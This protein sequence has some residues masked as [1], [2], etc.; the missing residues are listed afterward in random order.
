[1]PH[2]NL[3][4][5]QAT[6]DQ[7]IIPLIFILISLITSLILTVKCADSY[8][9]FLQPIVVILVLMIL[10]SV[11]CARVC[12]LHYVCVIVG[13]TGFVGTCICVYLLKSREDFYFFERQRN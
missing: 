4:R 3:Y 1:M 6:K 10:S 9:I 11:L 13:V 5:D 8:G 2:F 7:V 12:A